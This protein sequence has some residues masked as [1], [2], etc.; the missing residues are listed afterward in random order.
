MITIT[1]IAAKAGVSRATVSYVLNGQNTAV[2]ISDETR[3]R[4]MKVAAELG[5]RR[6]QLARAVITGQTRMLGLWVM[7]SQHEPVARVL[8]GIM[9]EADA[10]D[11]FVKLVGFDE[12]DERTSV[13]RVV[14]RCIEWRLAGIIAVHA[15][16]SA[17]DALQP[18][19]GDVKVPI[20]SVD[21]QGPRAGLIHITSDQQDALRQVVGHLSQLGHRRITFLGGR[22]EQSELLSWRR[23]HAYEAAMTGSD[24]MEF[25]DVR[26]G[27]WDHATTQKVAEELLSLPLGQRPT[28]IACWSDITAMNVIQVATRMGLRVPED[29][30][31]TGFDDSRAAALYNP[32]LTTIAQNF[33]EMG[34]HALRRLLARTTD[35][36]PLPEGAEE[37]L[38]TEL[39]VRESTAKPTG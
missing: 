32:P 27:Y 15:P 12:Y 21:S 22:P 3:E 5:Y 6:N 4:V 10:N 31:V 28:A 30:S 7:Q 37:C 1:D 38:K 18:Q 35:N 19:L 29:I 13:A 9:A 36:T 17:L 2:R 20:I 23:I 26:H 14:E 11:Y 16:E 8:A 33:E 25:I 39:V 34:R 24:L